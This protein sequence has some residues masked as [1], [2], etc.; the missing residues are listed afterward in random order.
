[1]FLNRLCYFI[2]ISGIE[3]PQCFLKYFIFIISL[4]TCLINSLKVLIKFFNRR[5]IK[6][7]VIVEDGVTALKTQKSIPNELITN[8]APSLHSRL[9]Y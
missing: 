9:K 5:I 7:E 3:G 6:D 4:F 2:K 1:M 8:S